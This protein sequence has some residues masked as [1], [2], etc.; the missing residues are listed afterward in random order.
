VRHE[1]LGELRLVVEHADDGRFVQ[2]RDDAIRHR[3]DRGQ[4]QRLTAQTALPEEIPLAME[5]DDRFLAQFG[6]DADLDLAVLYVNTASAGSPC[7]K[8]FRFYD[9]SLPYFRRHGGKKRV[10]AEGFFLVFATTLPVIFG[11]LIK[12]RLAF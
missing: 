4:T 8:T 6:D 1:H 11:L 10:C 3:R 2:P 5:C 12:Y 7:E 9:R